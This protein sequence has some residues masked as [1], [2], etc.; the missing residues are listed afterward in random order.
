[1]NRRSLLIAAC[2]GAALIQFAVPLGMIGRREAVLEGGRLFKFRTAPV[3]PYHPFQGRYVALNLEN[4]SSVAVPNG[5]SY[6]RGQRVYAHLVEDAD[7]FARVDRLSP[8]RPEGEDYFKTRV[9]YAGTTNVV[10]HLPFNQF[11]MPEHLAPKAEE[12]YRIHS[13]RTNRSAHVT[14]RVRNGYAVLENLFVDDKP[15]MDCLKE[16]HESRK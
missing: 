10:L 2:V 9:W 5:R 7:G 11:Y 12:Q 3:D 15:I 4:A 13:S 14:V 6:D 16:T 8:K 1:M